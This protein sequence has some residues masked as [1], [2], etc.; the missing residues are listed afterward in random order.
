[1]WRRAVCYKLVN[2]SE[3]CTTSIFRVEEWTKQEAGCKVSL[4]DACLA[5]SSTLKTEA[6]RFPEMFENF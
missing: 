4:S 1:M 3:E 2:F 5:Y 6:V